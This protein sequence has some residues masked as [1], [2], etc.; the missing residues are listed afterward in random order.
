MTSETIDYQALGHDEKLALV[1]EVRATFGSVAARELWAK[2]GLPEV[3]AQMPDA[4]QNW[5]NAHRGEQHDWPKL[6]VRLPPDAKKWLAAQATENGSS[7]NAEIIRSI[8]ERMSRA[9]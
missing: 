4:N 5:G 7:Q 8:R 1:T 6:M 2:L 3:A 9:A